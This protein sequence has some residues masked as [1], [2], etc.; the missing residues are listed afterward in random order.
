[1]KIS[2]NPGNMFG[3]DQASDLQK[4]LILF[5]SANLAEN[6]ANFSYFTETTY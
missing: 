5:G 1:M 2:K 6:N 3:P 4:Q